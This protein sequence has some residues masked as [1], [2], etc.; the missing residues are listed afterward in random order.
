M[1]YVEPDERGYINPNDIL[2]AI[3]S[4]TILVSVMTA[5]NEIGTIEPIKYIGEICKDH[6]ILFHTDAV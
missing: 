4:D 6:D 2:N 5:N 1:T 3:Q